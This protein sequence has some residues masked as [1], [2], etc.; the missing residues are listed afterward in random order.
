M[1]P[2][3]GSAHA[4]LMPT[5][6]ARTT[7]AATRAVAL[8]DAARL[9]RASGNHAGAEA[10]YRRALCVLREASIPMDHEAQGVVRRGYAALLVELGRDRDAADLECEIVTNQPTT[11]KGRIP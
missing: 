10:T 9:F 4:G 2:N 1:P 6:T 8:A 3:S 7:D 11:S 5:A